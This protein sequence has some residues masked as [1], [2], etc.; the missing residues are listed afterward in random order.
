MRS[1]G[2]HEQVLSAFKAGEVR[3]LLGT[4]MIAKGLDFPNVTLGGGGQRRH[5]ACTCPTSAPPSGPFN[6]WRR[7]PGARAGA[8]GRAGCWCR[9]TRPTTPRSA[10]RSRHDYEGFARS[11]LPER[12][13]YGVPPFGRLVR[14]IARGP[15]ESAVS[16]YMRDLA[17]AFRAG[18]RPVGP[19]PRA[20]PGPDPQD[21]Q[22][23]SVP[24]PV[25]LSQ[26]PDR[27]RSLASTVPRAASPRRMASSWRSTSTR[28][29]CCD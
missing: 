21:P 24:P 13:K 9:P 27:S 14:L 11:E 18:G 16:A 5:G 2:S 19:H 29:P 26:L 1:P 10:R 23:L 7:W 28:S 4:Q 12:E 25:A 22:P 15:E 17:A 20:G 8:I 6:S 3:I